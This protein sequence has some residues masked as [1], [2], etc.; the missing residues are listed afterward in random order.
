MDEAVNMERIGIIAAMSQERDACLRFIKK[1]KRS[2]LGP[3]RC[4]HFRLVDR[5]CRLLTS[6]MGLKRA[7]QATRT[8]I[9][10]F[11]PQLLVSMGVAGAVSA[12]L[13]IGDV[14]ASRN[15]CL[16]DKGLPTHF[17][18]LA[19][20]SDAAW[21][22]A[23]QALQPRGARLFSGT[24]VTTR[25]SQFVQ[26]QAEELTNPVFEMETV[27]IARIAAERGVP[28]LS[29]R[30]ISDGPQEPIPFDLEGMMDEDANLRMGKLFKAIIAYPRIIPQLLRMGWNTTKAAENAAIA[31]I[32]ALCQ[33]GPII[34][35]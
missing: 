3:F 21:Q 29:L 30:A 12:E 20:L 17:Q 2:F 14:V 4:D 32:A 27:G 13:K 23:V 24:A 1:G 10:A 25:G 15:T 26:N 8:L 35:Q 31:L 5:D 9:E 7:A 34:S 16:L 22:A 28:L 18:P 19:L 33:L 11:R 6:G